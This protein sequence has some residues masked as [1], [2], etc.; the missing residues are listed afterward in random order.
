[1]EWKKKYLEENQNNQ[2]LKRYR[3]LQGKKKGNNK[4]GRL[5]QVS[6]LSGRYLHLLINDRQR[7]FMVLLQAPM[8]AFLIS[9]VKDGGQFEKYGITKSLLFA[10]SCS[11]FWIGTLNAIQEVC[12]ERNILRREYMTGLHLSSY[13]FS[14]FI[15]LG[16]LCFVQ[17][18]LLTGVFVLMVGKPDEGV[19]MNPAAELF[20]TT[21]LT[22]FSAAGMGLFA[23]SFFKNADRAMTVAPILLMPQILF[24][25]LLFELKGATKVISWFAIC[26]WSMEGYGS[27][28]NLNSLSKAVTLNGKEVEIEHKAEEF[29]EFSEKHLLTAWLILF[30][31]IAAFG[32]LCDITLRN[33][34]KSA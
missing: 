2:E 26:R 13:V 3:T 18:F 22:S 19:F 7:L 11:A 9:L 24:S 6:V 25:G 33:I 31:F 21:F 1:M 20:I 16:I 4:H 32:L 29:F 34:K 10:L 23:S 17:S 27:T 30:V 15:V 8:L 12:K 14:K 28:V 5:R